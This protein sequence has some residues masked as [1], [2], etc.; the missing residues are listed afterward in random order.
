MCVIVF[1]KMSNGFTDKIKENPD[2]E[3]HKLHLP[4]H[5]NKYDCSSYNVL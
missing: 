4:D 1:L 3:K 5:S 2:E